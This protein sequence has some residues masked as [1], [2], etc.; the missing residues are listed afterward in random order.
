MGGGEG[1]SGG[2]SLGEPVGVAGDGLCDAGDWRRGCA[3]LSDADA[4]AD[5]VHVAGLWSKGGGAVVARAV[6]QAVGCGGS[7]GAGACGGY[8]CRRVSECR[9]LRRVDGG[10]EGKAAEGCWV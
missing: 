2:D 8:G 10:G 7:A 9:E 4:G 6:R 5:W 1:R 3:A